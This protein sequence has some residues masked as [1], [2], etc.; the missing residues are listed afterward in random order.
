[1]ECIDQ[2]T[3]SYNGFS[4][5]SA[6]LAD[7]KLGLQLR[8][9]VIQSIYGPTSPVYQVHETGLGAKLVILK[10]IRNHFKKLIDAC[11]PELT[12]GDQVTRPS[13]LC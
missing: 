5:N 9:Y 7:A 10:E 11:T 13:V 4:A 6:G 1:M 3:L 2:A 12:R 8:Q